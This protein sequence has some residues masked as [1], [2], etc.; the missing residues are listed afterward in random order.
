MLSAAVPAAL[1]SALM[2]VPPRVSSARVTV[3]HLD[4]GID[5]TH[6]AL[7]RNVWINQAEIPAAVKR[8]LHDV[9]GDGRIGFDDLNH[10]ANRAQVHDVNGNGYI[11]A[12]DL[13][14]PRSAGGWADGINARSHRGDRY[15]DDIVGWDFAENDNNPFDDGFFGGHGTHTAGIITGRSDRLRGSA[16]AAMLMPLRI[17][18]DSGAPASDAAIARAIR[19]AADNGAAVAS[20]SWGRA[21]G[22][23]DDRV[24]AALKHA[25]ERGM[26]LVASSGNTGCDLD[27]PF[28][29]QFPADYELRNVLSVTAVDR[30]GRIPEY[31]SYGRR[32]VDVAAPGDAIL[33]AAPGGAYVRLSGA[34]M[35]SAYV[36]GRA[37]AL[38][39]RD[40]RIRGEAL[41]DAVV[42]RAQMTPALKGKVGFGLLR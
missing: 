31:A 20:A 22:D 34:S 24:F 13:L 10:R 14:A 38:A 28:A 21:T 2:P 26:L 40:S 35:A 15:V 4:T 32:S 9:N 12:A 18:R 41:K 8:R 3:A 16:P 6:P 27:R 23:K 37:A 1:L 42:R 25:G 19:Y 17:F 33:S 29:S 36:A 5:Y 39:A 7:Y 11:D 30:R